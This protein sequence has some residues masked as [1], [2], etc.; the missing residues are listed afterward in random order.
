MY[1][2][3]N[4]ENDAE[5]NLQQIYKN[6]LKE[7]ANNNNGEIYNKDTKQKI[8][9]KDILKENKKYS[10]YVILGKNA[11]TK[12][13]NLDSGHTTG[14]CAIYNYGDEYA[15]PKPPIELMSDVTFDRE[16]DKIT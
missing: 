13:E 2:I 9:I 11:K 5:K 6:M 16:I 7:Y 12:I 15:I 4:K 3:Y 14:W 1:L 10:P 8:K